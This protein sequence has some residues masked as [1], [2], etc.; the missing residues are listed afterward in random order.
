[1]KNTKSAIQIKQLNKAFGKKPILKSVSLTVP[2]GEIFGFLGPNG[3]GKTTTIR[4]MMDFIRGD[5]GSIRM[6]GLDSQDASLQLKSRIGY[7]PSDNH[8]NEKWTGAEHISFIASLRKVSTEMPDIIRRLN[9]DVVSK[10]KHLSSGNK[11]KLSIILALIGDPELLI[12]DEPTQGLD[13]LFQNEIY[14]ILHGLQ[15]QGKTVFISSHNLAEVQKLCSRV[16]IIREG[17]IVAEEALDSLREIST[18]QVMVRFNKSVPESAFD[19]KGVTVI[20]YKPKEVT[21]KVH[22]ELDSIIKLLAQ[23]SVLDLQVEHV[24]LEE[25]FMELYQ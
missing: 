20:E 4:C 10:V 13:P 9:F 12:L 17:K 19:L 11:Q 6:F 18:H 23:Y 3:A 14:D 21:L 2:K 7:V 1:M 16:A 8:L 24:S 15:N 22:G 5:S 25:I